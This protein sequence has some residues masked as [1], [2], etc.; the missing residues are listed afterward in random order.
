MLYILSNTTRSGILLILNNFVTNNSMK[1]RVEA[2]PVAHYAS[3]RPVPRTVGTDK[4][5]THLCLPSSTVPPIRGSAPIPQTRE[6]KSL[7]EPRHNLTSTL[8]DVHILLKM[9]IFYLNRHNSLIKHPF[10]NLFV[11]L[12]F[13]P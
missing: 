9:C 3:A 10:S 5:T 8:K 6:E 11:P 7:S 12:C 1:D 13:F 2:R 4:S